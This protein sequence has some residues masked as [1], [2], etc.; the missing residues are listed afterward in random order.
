MSCFHLSITCVGATHFLIDESTNGTFIDGVRAQRGT[1]VCLRSGALVSLCSPDANCD[2]AV[3]FRFIAL[4]KAEQCAEE[5]RHKRKAWVPDDTEA[6]ATACIVCW[7]AHVRVLYLPCTHLAVCAT[8]DA[9]LQRRHC[10]LCQTE[11]RSSV[12]ARFP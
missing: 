7:A 5:L 1:P 12:L 10:P 11:I 9:G 3:V 4:T 8:C 6:P 2:K